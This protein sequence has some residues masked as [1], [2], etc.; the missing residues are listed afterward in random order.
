MYSVVLMAALTA[1]A[2]APDCWWKHGCY[3]CNGCYGCAGCYGCYGCN[4]CYGCHGGGWQCHG[5]Y[6]CYGCHGCTGYAPGVVI[7]SGP[8]KAPPPKEEKEKKGEAASKAKLI[9]EVPADAK[10]YID[11]Q[12]MKIESPRRVFNTPR[13]DKDQAYYYILRVQVVREGKTYSETR[14]V[15]IRAG[16][17]VRASFPELEDAALASAVANARR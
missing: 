1:G 9:V 8:E 2:E 6:G 13:L 14:R 16:D 12:L 4:G 5:C 7:P 17:E 3:S 10:L 15:I 11:D